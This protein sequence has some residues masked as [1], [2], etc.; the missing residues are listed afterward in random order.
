MIDMSFQCEHPVVAIKMF[1]KLDGKQILKFMPQRLDYSI[2]SLKTKYGENNVYLL[3]CTKCESCRRKY[4]EQW[5]IRCVLEAKYHKFNYFLTLTY[6]DIHIR[7]SSH[8]DIKHLFRVLCGH[9]YKK[10]IR[11]FGCEERG[12]LTNRKHYHIVLFCDFPLDLYDC[13]KV[14][15][16]Y[17]YH[18]KAIDKAWT[19]GLYNIAPFETNCSRYVAK[20]TNKGD[21]RIFMSRNLGKQYVI[22]NYDKII[23]D[24]FIIYGDFNDKKYTN[25]PTCFLNMFIADGNDNAIKR[26]DYLRS[27]ARVVQCSKARD[28]RAEHQEVVIRNDIKRVTDKVKKRRKL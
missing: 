28:L 7:S 22:D 12:E 17:Y 1:E 4:A 21:S 27:L 25:L 11:F 10:K 26:K 6:D 24:N 20:Y 13:T 2:D 15:G 14:N 23:K 3:P 19:F 9:D 18:S 16:Y 8:K 5:S